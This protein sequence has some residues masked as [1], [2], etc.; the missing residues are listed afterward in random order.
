LYEGL[1]MHLLALLAVGSLT[2]TQLLYS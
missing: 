1:G 2:F